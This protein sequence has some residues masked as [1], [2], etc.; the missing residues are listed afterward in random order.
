MLLFIIYIIC[1]IIMMNIYGVDAVNR[2]LFDLLLIFDMLCD[3][4]L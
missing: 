2:F 1:M 3:M 4:I